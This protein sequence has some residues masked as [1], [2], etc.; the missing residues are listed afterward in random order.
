MNDYTCTAD[1]ENPRQGAF[2]SGETEVHHEQWPLT[3]FRIPDPVP[4]M[5][6]LAEITPSLRLQVAQTCIVADYRTLYNVL[7]ILP[8]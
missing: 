8:N 4:D 5:E 3:T 6:K 1:L 2:I 7:A